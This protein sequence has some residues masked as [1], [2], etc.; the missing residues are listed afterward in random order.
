MSNER[1]MTDSVL[2]T[3]YYICHSFTVIFVPPAILI[4]GAG[5]AFAQAIGIF[6]G[7]LAAIFS[8]F[9]GSCIGAVIAFVRSRYMMRD[10]IYLF[11]KRYP[12]VRAA[13]RGT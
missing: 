9:L 5:Y 13:D 2:L 4:F 1:N 3:R 8:C 12:V 7:S 6:N 11:A 10:L